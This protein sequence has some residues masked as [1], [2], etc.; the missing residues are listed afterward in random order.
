MMLP[1]WW[2]AGRIESKASPFFRLLLAAGLSGV[3]YLT[4]VNLAGRLFHQ[5]TVP[6]GLYLAGSAIAALWLWRRDDQGLTLEP[7]WR[8]RRDWAGMLVIALALGIPQIVLAVSTPYWDEVASSAIHLT[9]ANQFAE[10]VFPPRHNALPD[11]PIKY[12]YAFAILSGTVR[13]LT[14]LSANVSVD[15]VSSALWIFTF[16]F[17]VQWMLALGFARPAALWGATATLLGGGLAWIFVRRIEAYS[18]FEVAPG[19][20]S[21]VHRYDATRSVVANLVGDAR[22]PSVHLR[23]PDGS[24]SNLPWDIAAQFQQHAVS[25]GIAL[26]VF[27]L[28][29]FVTWQQREERR[30]PLLIATVLT[31]GVLFLAHAV[32]GGVAAVTAGIVL[33]FSFVLE[34]TRRRFMDGA[35]FGIGVAIV[36]VLHGGLLTFGAQYG[37]SADV[38][39]LRDRFGYSRGGVSGFL[40]WN[41]AGF[42]LPLVLAIVAL[43]RPKVFGRRPAAVPRD[44]AF[45]VLMV[46][47]AFSYLIPQIAFYSSETIGVEQFTEISKFFFTAHLGLALLSVWGVARLPQRLR[48]AILLPS[49]IAMAVT[50]LMFAWVHSTSAGSS[51]LRRRWLGPYFAP[52]HRGSIEQQMGERLRSLKRTNHD[53]YFDASADERTHEYLSEMLLFGGSV[54]TLTPSRYERT[55]VGYR[56]SQGVV[57]ARLVKNGWMAQLRPGAAEECDCRWYYARPSKDMAFAPAFVRARF[58]KLVA[59]STFVQRLAGADRV[60]YSIER[61]T[62]QLDRDIHRFWRPRVVMQPSGDRRELVFYDYDGNRVLQGSRWLDGP[63]WLRGELAQPWIARFRGSDR[64]TLVFGRAKD[65][66][67]RLGRR[68]VDLVEQSNWGWSMRQPDGTWSP[69]LERWGWNSDI[70]LVARTRRDGFDSHVMYSPRSGKWF[71]AATGELPGPS[72][73]AGDLPV[74][75]AGRFLRG[76]DADLGVRSRVD[77]AFVIQSL[78]NGKRVDFRWGLGPNEVLVPGDYD[79]DGY[80]E[81]GVYNETNG[82][83]Y[84]RKVPDGAITQFRFGA[85]GAVPMP[86]DYN[87]DGKLDPAY[88]DARAGK[89]YVT[90][91]QGRSVDRVIDVPPH[92]IPA[93]VNVF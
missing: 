56:L 90:F 73:P 57:A 21:L 11:I 41:L 75:F 92:S 17:V 2:V 60:L 5:S 85:A 29:A 58:D 14:G 86:F 8:S 13:W 44:L 68:I 19:A 84:W 66:D 87:H 45:I 80:D 47:A 76:S 37:A 93:F 23:N 6:A 24:L 82:F 91:T 31:F 43:I 16:L 64:P 89:I 18:T 53:T 71:D 88:W 48:G 72:L 69:E 33:L 70:P 28:W 9:A 34:P 32:F 22:V 67:F 79:G 77:G 81:I 38:L 52:Y 4:F 35:L 7:L 20:E 54:F 74:P 62:S 36:A 63:S 61:P 40:L 25:L 3:G 46:F 50:P 12:H 65:T 15:L 26:T 51:T 10:G 49:A 39:T 42:G 55:G 78:S 1:A 83:W 59:E 27:A 30:T